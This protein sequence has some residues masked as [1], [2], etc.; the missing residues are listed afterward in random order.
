VTEDLDSYVSVA[1]VEEHTT[2]N[3]TQNMKKNVGK[4]IAKNVGD[5]EGDNAGEKVDI[6]ILFW[7]YTLPKQ[8]KPNQIWFTELHPHEQSEEVGI[9]IDNVE[10][11]KYTLYID[12]IGYQVNDIYSQFIENPNILKDCQAEAKTDTIIIEATHNKLN[13]K[14]DLKDNQVVRI[15]GTL[16]KSMV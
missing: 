4:N 6:N 15:T 7:D 9:T 2:K 8:D 1:F 3:M 14:Y 16:M 5:N 11:D 12:T 10:N 13:I